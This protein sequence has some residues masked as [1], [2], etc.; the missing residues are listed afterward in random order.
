[1]DKE[2]NEQPRFP[3]GDHVEDRLNTE[4]INVLQKIL[5]F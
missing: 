5:E 3:M 4:S 2:V 1:M